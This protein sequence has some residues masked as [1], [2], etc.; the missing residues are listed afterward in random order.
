[1]RGGP[2][3][4]LDGQPHGIVADFVE[5]RGSAAT[6][7]RPAAGLQL[8]AGLLGGALLDRPL[9]GRQRLDV[10]GRPGAAGAPPAAVELPG[11][12]DDLLLRGGQILDALR[13]R[14]G[15][16]GLALRRHELVVEGL[17]FQEVDVAA[18]FRRRLAAADIARAHVIGHE[19]AGRDLEVLE[20]DH[21]PAVGGEPEAR[22]GE[23]HDD[24]GLAGFLQHQ[25]EAADAEVVVG[26]GLDQ[27]FFERC[28][29][30]IA[31]RPDHAHVGR[32]VEQRADEVLGV[33]GGFDA[34]V[35]D[36][37]HAVGAIGQHREPARCDAA[38]DAQGHARAV[39]Q[40]DRAGLH[41][42][43]GGHG[44]A[45]VGALGRVDVAAVFFPA[46]VEFEC[47]R[48]GVVEIDALHLGGMH[49]GDG[50]VARAKPAGAHPVGERGR[51]LGHRDGKGAAFASG[52]RQR[53]RVGAVAGHELGRERGGA[54][55]DA[56]DDRHRAA[57][58]HPYVAG[59]HP[60]LEA[61][62]HD[63][64]RRDARGFGHRPDE[65]RHGQRQCHGGPESG[66]PRIGEVG[67]GHDPVGAISRHRSQ[68]RGRQAI[69]HER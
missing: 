58:A 8:V 61:R 37:H 36:Q 53:L 7:R 19:I 23:R 28:D 18:R 50:V 11:G 51:Y 49:D 1:M 15:S 46:W 48:V 69:G 24:L 38:R 42:P 52:H 34:V 56:C 9:G 12:D 47:R 17:H 32:T 29:L 16:H 5:P 3:H 65:E 10:G 2:P 30:A 44:Q 27:H 35:L 40:D 45:D 20:V 14:A 43:V 31:G 39:G 22:A 4:G 13:L 41:R 57:G 6:A 66:A 55:E 64:G 59:I 62:G 25:V 21:V 26:A 60:D 54:A 68:R 33:V 63:V 67:P